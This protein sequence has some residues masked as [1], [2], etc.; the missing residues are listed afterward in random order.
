M[1]APSSAEVARLTLTL[2]RLIGLYLRE[3]L[4]PSEN[5]AENSDLADD[6]FEAEPMDQL[7][8]SSTSYRIAVRP[9]QGRKVFTLPLQLP[10][11]GEMFDAGSVRLAEFSLHA[12]V[13]ARAIE[14]KKLERAHLPVCQPARGRG[15]ASVAYNEDERP[16][17]GPTFSR[18]PCNRQLWVFRRPRSSSRKPIWHRPDSKRKGPQCA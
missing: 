10:W 18:P 14:R 11:C 12:G 17:N 6:V 9:Q 15:A 7:L 16:F 2:A 5:D 1:R 8:G 13:A 4:G 3:R